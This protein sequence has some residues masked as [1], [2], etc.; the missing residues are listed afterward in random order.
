MMDV[1]F[2]LLLNEGMDFAQEYFPEWSLANAA[3]IKALFSKVN[4]IIQAA[5]SDRAKF[6]QVGGGD[7]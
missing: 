4:I 5:E 3:I 7:G 2:V 1:Q 6:I